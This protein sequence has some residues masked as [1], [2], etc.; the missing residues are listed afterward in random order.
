MMVNGFQSWSSREMS[1]AHRLPRL[2]LPAYPFRP[3]GDYRL[4]RYSGRCGH[5]HSWTYTYFITVR[6]RS[7]AGSRMRER[8]TPLLITITDAIA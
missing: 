2:F 1:P 6:V 7:S 8:V 5:L 4:H 3:Y